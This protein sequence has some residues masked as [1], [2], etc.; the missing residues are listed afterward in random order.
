MSIRP[1]PAFLISP[2]VPDDPAEYHLK[3]KV[4]RLHLRHLPKLL[5]SDQWSATAGR[6]KKSGYGQPEYHKRIIDESGFIL[7]HTSSD[8]VPEE[9][10]TKQFVQ[11]PDL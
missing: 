9:V 8:P 6:K 10:C 5:P 2:I 4:F 7:L 11:I 1:A 3:E